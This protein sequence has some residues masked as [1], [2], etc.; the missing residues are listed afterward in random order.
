[1]NTSV[2]N[3]EVEEE[4][5]NFNGPEDDSDDFDDEVFDLDIDSSTI[6]EFDDFD[7]DGDDDDF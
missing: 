4:L 7:D 6:V 2:E 5:M 3:V 1:M